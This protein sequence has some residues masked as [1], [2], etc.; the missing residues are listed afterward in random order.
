MLTSDTMIASN[1]ST[2]S[3]IGQDFDSTQSDNSTM[4]SG[5]TSTWAKK[6]LT[7]TK[8]KHKAVENLGLKNNVSNLKV[9]AY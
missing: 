8:V 4:F 3:T 6:D 7:L 2:G 1:P 9:R 5:Q